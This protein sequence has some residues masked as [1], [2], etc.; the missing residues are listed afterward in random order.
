MYSSK[1]HVPQMLQHMCW[2]HIAWNL[3]K[4]SQADASQLMESSD[5]ILVNQS[6]MIPS[7]HSSASVA[8]Q[9]MK[10]DNR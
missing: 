8:G 5:L 9:G 6:L 1:L 7:M 2:D 3:Q 10:V 4:P